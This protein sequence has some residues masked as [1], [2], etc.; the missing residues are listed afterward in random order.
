MLIDFVTNNK[1]LAFSIV[2]KNISCVDLSINLMHVNGMTLN[3]DGLSCAESS[4]FH[5]FCLFL[6]NFPTPNF[7]HKF[8][9]II[10]FPW[11][12]CKMIHKVINELEQNKFCLKYMRP[13]SLILYSKICMCSRYYIIFLF[14]ISLVKGTLLELYS[15]SLMLFYSN[16]MIK[17]KLHI[18]LQTLTTTL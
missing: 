6:K 3:I 17:K 12:C 16:E 15:L 18:I 11:C 8:H 7:N 2:M 13:S 4:I 9:T 5:V 1:A 10:H 14:L